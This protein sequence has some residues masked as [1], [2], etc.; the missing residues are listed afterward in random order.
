MEMFD[1]YTE[2]R[3]KTNRTIER[4]TSLEKNDYRLVVHA[5][6]INNKNEMLI[7][8]RQLFKSGWANMWDITVGGS[9]IAGETS[10]QAVQ[11]EL[12]EELGINMDFSDI[13]PQF[14]INFENGFD[15]IYII[16]RNDIDITTLKLQ[17]EEVQCVK[18]A[19]FN[20]IQ[21][22][23]HKGTFIPYYESLINL[24]FS[25]KNNYGVFSSTEATN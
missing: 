8:Q 10:K 22:M 1:I 21:E 5:C 16:Q 6:I 18:W 11:R 4:G 12:F 9:A 19:S 2:N 24:I 17:Y 3:E 7:Q 23:L 20:E 13:R 14:T 15:D 25:M